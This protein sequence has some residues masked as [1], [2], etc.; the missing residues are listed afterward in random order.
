GS[1]PVT[2]FVEEVLRYDSPVQLTSRQVFGDDLEIAGV[3]LQRNT[4]VLLLLGAANRDPNRYDD[5]DR[6]DP[7]R[8]DIAPLSFGAGAHYCLGQA[9]ARLEAAT[10]FPRLLER[11]PQLAP[12][13]DEKP[14]RRDRLVLRGYETLPV[15]V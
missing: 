8:K 13:A 4:E 6:F 9:L 1:I 10:V 7:L 5:P 12:A 11:F 2:G 15:T 3:R 14:V